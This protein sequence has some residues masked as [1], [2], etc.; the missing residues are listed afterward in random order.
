M[1]ADLVYD[2]RADPHSAPIDGRILW[3]GAI[4]AGIFVVITLFYFISSNMPEENLTADSFSISA[5]QSLTAIASSPTNIP[6][7]I[8]TVA[9]TDSPSLSTSLP[10]FTET[11]TP[12][13]TLT[14]TAPTS[15]P[16]ITFTATPIVLK[17]STATI[18]VTFTSTP[19][20]TQIPPHSLEVPIGKDQLYLIHK[21][22]D[23]EN[24]AT[25]AGKYQTSLEAILA[26]NSTLA[27]PI[28]IDAVVII[29]LK[30]EN[31]LGLPKLEPYQVTQTQITPEALAELLKT[32]MA[33]FKFF[34]DLK[35]GEKLI[36]GNW[37]LV[38]R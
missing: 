22:V 27:I 9:P 4:L 16:T 8:D 31:P 36:K 25:L 10:L 3:T 23:G 1:P 12:F 28:R 6:T 32:D 13:P 20:S 26:V 18:S 14:P 5:V 24:L 30:N 19:T 33:L 38:P 11:I 17:T 15:T 29:P 2:G 37:V 35:D 7:D 21:V 34:N